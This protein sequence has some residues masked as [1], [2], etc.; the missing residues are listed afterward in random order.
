MLTKCYVQGSL[1]V[2]VSLICVSSPSTIVW[3]L[4]DACLYMFTESV[5]VLNVNV[6]IH[7][8]MENFICC[9]LDVETTA[10][11]KRKQPAQQ[12]VQPTH[13]NTIKDLFVS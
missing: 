4:S 9:R 6:E 13:A 11:T 2:Q 3:D 7:E 8:T 1:V 12:L 5:W 10:A